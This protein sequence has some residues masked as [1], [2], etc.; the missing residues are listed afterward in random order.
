MNYFKKWDRI[1]GWIVFA[2]AAVVYLLTIEPTASLWDCAEFISTSYKL[3]VGHPPGA[4]L[5]MMISRLFTMFA[6]SPEYAAVMVNAMSALA[7][8]FTILFLFWSITHLG[9]RIMRRHASEMN[10]TQ[11]WTVMGA[12]I[13]GAIAYTFTDTFWFSAVEGEVYALSS[14]FTAVVIWAML[15]WEEVADQPHA[16]RWLILIAYL[17][18]LSIGV[19]ILNLLTIPALVFVYYFKRTPKV[20]LWGVVKAT[21]IACA[22]LLFINNII[23]PHTTGIGAA[24]DR[25][26][27]NGLG[28]PVNS[29]LLTFMLVL[30][31][32]LGFAVYITHKKG[33]V[34]LNTVALC[35]SV[36]LIGYC[37]YASMI[38][39]AAANP[40]MNSNDPDNAYSLLYV[41]NRDQYG[42]K[43]LLF[44]AQYSAPP[45][46]IKYQKKYYFDPESGEYKDYNTIDGVEYPEEFTTFFP[47]MWSSLDHHVSGYQT[48]GQID[49]GRTVNYRGQQYTVP[50]AGQNLRFFFNYQLNF[51]YWRYFL[52][53][54]VG[55]QSDE[56]SFGQITDGQWLSGI[57][58]IDA[59]YLGP[60]DNLPSEMAN[61][62]GR[63]KY[64]FLPFILG[65]IGLIY[66]LN[67]D[68][69]NFTVV[70]WLFIMMGVALVVY[71]NT[72]P[73]EPRE[74][75]Y[76]YAGSFYAFCI[77]IGLGVMCV[78]DW[79][80]R[81]AKRDNLTVTAVATAIC[82]CVPILLG[83]QNWDD[84]DRSHRY[85]ARDIGYNFLMTCLPNSIIMNYGDNDTFP[86]WYNQ[87]VEGIRPD[88]RIMNMSYLASSWYA[89]E[90]KYRYNE[91]A[92]VPISLPLHKYVFT[93]NDYVE[94]VEV[95]EEPK[96][97]KQV[98]DFV[99][100]DDPRSRLPLADNSLVDF[101]PTKTLL[102]PVN[103][104]N[105]VACGIVKPEDAHL[106]VDTI[107]IKLGNAIDKSQLLLLDILSNFDWNRPLYF[108][109]PSLVSKLGLQ[110]YLQ[111][112]GIAYRLVPIKTP[113]I[114]PWNVGRIDPDVM[115]ENLMHVYRYGNVADPRVY[116]DSYV[117]YNF[118]VN[119]IRIAFAR[120]AAI[121]ADRGEK[122]KAVEVLDYGLEVMPVSQFRYTYQ[123]APYIRAYYIAGAIDK[124]DAL[125]D[126]YA[127]NLEE[128]VDYF[129]SFPSR[130]QYLV[131]NELTEKLTILAE[132]YRIADDFNRPDQANRIMMLFDW[133]F[134]SE[135]LLDE[136]S[137]DPADD[138][139]E[140]VSAGD[141]TTER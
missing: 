75:D 107:T 80:A 93:E 6:P 90:M 76:V 133:L 70:M 85:V 110:D 132:L 58:P 82:S 27:V 125:F 39:R 18:G 12:G 5:F 48:W 20:T 137:Y 10:V 140:I 3:E 129:M 98:I 11:T 65:I 67:R 74:R 92:P 25:W 29:G 13:I 33:K 56:Q 40:P 8:A 86:L 14:L 135:E 30:F 84:H 47:R 130:K 127:D 7:S 134:G 23:I 44:G 32:A 52:W 95:L 73:S 81:L 139:R 38:I 112:D 72:P 4:P 115:Y 89:E 124:G 21:A 83:A 102:L 105:A 141:I 15:K 94:V 55:R 122:D 68:P 118:D 16:N 28:L 71:F 2:A 106:M 60:Q 97:V 9:R 109:T 116:V 138:T 31:A 103:K 63:N 101:I 113:Y 46:G 87:E 49:K 22:I 17:M 111:F 64:Y 35:L 41:L 53:N 128:Y 91:S 69:K 43:P 51:M 114:D 117:N 26:F 1:T 120:L 108:T 96:T 119:N 79:I 104:E 62:K 50:T 66:Q 24:V 19:H 36:I 100:S 126:S 131:E 57:E 78:R 37:S 42:N 136:A 45:S 77:W 61:N 123:Y 54:F 34:L 121:L 99:R 88:V 59:V